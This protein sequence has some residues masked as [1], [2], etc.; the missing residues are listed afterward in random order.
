LYTA[1]DDGSAID[2]LPSRVV[3]VAVVVTLGNDGSEDTVGVMGSEVLL[4]WEEDD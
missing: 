3:G 2:E 4:V 1:L